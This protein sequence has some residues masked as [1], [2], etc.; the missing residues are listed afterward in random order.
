M[1]SN[2]APTAIDLF[3]GCGGLTVGLKQAGFHVLGAVDIDPLSMQTYKANHPKVKTWREDIRQLDPFKVAEALGLGEQR[4]DLLAGCPPCQG[5]STMRTRNGRLSVEDP[6][7]DLLLEFQCFV[8]ALR[9]RVVMLENVPGLLKDQRF[10][11]FRAHLEDIG[12]VGEPYVLDVSRYGVPQRRKRLLYLAG[13][14]FEVPLA[15]PLDKQVTVREAIGDLPTS[16]TSG[17]TAHD[18]VEHRSQRVLDLIR[19]IPKDGGSR[20]D[21][22]FADQLE[23][24]KRCNGFKD[25]YGRMKWDSVAPTITGGCFNPSKG[26]FL[27]PEEDR[28]ITM[29]EA[30]LLQGFPCDYRFPTIA[31][32]AS[33]ALMIGNAL[34]PPFIQRHAESVIAGLQPNALVR[35]DVNGVC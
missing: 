5:F 28:A 4:L 34:P 21:L 25:V 18:I 33:V 8:E 12:Y 7:N 3:C 17:D 19:R 30:A 22:P 24:H 26:R 13:Q 11:D 15:A 29:R 9:P 14:G 2:Q 1:E 6:R 31:N 23:C 20:T 27:H 10:E 32:K 35:G 16:G